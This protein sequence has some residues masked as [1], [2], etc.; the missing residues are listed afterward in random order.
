MQIKIIQ[1]TGP[2][3][4]FMKNESIIFELIVLIVFPHLHLLG[5]LLSYEN[6]HNI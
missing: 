5:N 1:K 6:P 2:F 4:N 3:L